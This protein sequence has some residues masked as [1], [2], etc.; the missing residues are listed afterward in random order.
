[1][2]LFDFITGTS[3]DTHLSDIA[4]DFKQ[5]L[6]AEGERKKYIQRIDEEIIKLCDDSINHASK[7]KRIFMKIKKLKE[8]GVVID[9]E[10]AVSDKVKKWVEDV[11]TDIQD[12]TKTSEE[13]RELKVDEEELE[14]E[15]ERAE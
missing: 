8:R 4:K 7:R 9:P 2:G 12:F 11:D 3:H 15:E 5:E 14:Q 6:E 1:M 13:E 10:H